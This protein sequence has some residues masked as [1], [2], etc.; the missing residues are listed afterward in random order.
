MSVETA[1]IVIAGLG[2][3][4]VGGIVAASLMGRRLGEKERA[5]SECQQAR[6]TA[7]ARAEPLQ[8]QLDRKEQ[9]LAEFQSEL[10]NLRE[11]CGNLEGEAAAQKRAFDEASQKL[12]DVFRSTATKVLDTQREHFDKDLE[13][14]KESIDTLLKPV[15]EKLKD[16]N[17][18]IVELERNRIGAYKGLSEQVHALLQSQQTLQ[19]DTVSLTQAL[20]GSSQRGRWGELQ[21]RRLVE[22]AEMSPYCDYDEQSSAESEEGRNRPDLIV[23]LPNGNRVIVDS[24]AP[25]HIWVEA[26][27]STTPESREQKMRQFA[28]QVKVAVGGLG[29][30]SYWNQFESVEF[31]VMFLPG[32]HYLADALRADPTLLEYSFQKRVVLAT[33]TTLLGLLR[34]VQLGWQQVKLADAAKKIADEGKKLHGHVCVWSS[35]FESV[36][37]YFRQA[38]E[39]LDKTESTANRGILSTAARL[40]RLGA[41]SEKSLPANVAVDLETLEE[42]AEMEIAAVLDEAV[43]EAPPFAIANGALFEENS[44]N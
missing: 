14:R 11:R 33:P 20:R 35:H 24:K 25:F 8:A 6:A 7:E 32:E 13:R 30:K 12:E 23:K 16:L 26:E 17:Q 41:R 5:L 27:E 37:K 1:W 15:D 43:S 28:A 19:K 42:A 2:G 36:K 40:E 18:Q 21:L 10:S 39:A 44:P 29:Q 3:L 9:Q 38:S 31:V 4:T 34:T 22:M